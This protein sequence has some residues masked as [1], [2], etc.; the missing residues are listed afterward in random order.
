MQWLFRTAQIDQYTSASLIARVLV[1][2]FNAKNRA[3]N[4]A[5]L[6][7]KFELVELRQNDPSFDCEVWALNAA[8]ALIDQR[9]IRLSIPH[10]ELR[11][12][13]RAHATHSMTEMLSGRLVI[14]D[15]DDIPVLDLRSPE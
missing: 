1:A 3:S 9:I 4:I 12:T 14:E 8:R 10:H 15:Q 13:A 7:A 6:Q 5:L 11:A 2:K